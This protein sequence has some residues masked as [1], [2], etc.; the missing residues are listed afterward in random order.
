MSG[1]FKCKCLTNICSQTATV[2]LMSGEWQYHSNIIHTLFPRGLNRN[3]YR[4]DFETDEWIPIKI[5]VSSRLPSLKNVW[6]D[7]RC[8][9]V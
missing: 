7:L 4:W 3:M 8:A 1:V 6:S 5:R 2:R 9:Y